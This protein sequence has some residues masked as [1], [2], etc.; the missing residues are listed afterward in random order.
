MLDSAKAQGRALDSV[1]GQQ[2]E[3]VGKATSEYKAWWRETEK[4]RAA[5]DQ[6]RASLDPVYA[7]TARYEAEVQKLTLALERGADL[8]VTAACTGH[9][10]A[11]YLR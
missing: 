8:A 3:R 2:V 7:A 9:Q 10:A 11:S 5:V 4:A 1:F 6:L